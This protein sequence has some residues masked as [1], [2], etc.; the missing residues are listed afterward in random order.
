MEDFSKAPGG[1]EFSKMKAQYSMFVDTVISKQVCVSIFTP[2]MMKL[3]QTTWIEIFVEGVI[4]KSTGLTNTHI[5][6]AYLVR[7]Q[8][9]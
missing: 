4:D 1:K 8:G 9:L 3:S 7:V 5:Q 6:G 2:K